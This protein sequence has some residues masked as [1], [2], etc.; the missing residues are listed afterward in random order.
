MTFQWGQWAADRPVNS[1]CVEG[2]CDVTDMVHS[3]RTTMLFKP[4]T[5]THA[6]L[7]ASSCANVRQGLVGQRYT[8]HSQIQQADRNINSV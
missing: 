1:F 3:K 6:C 2:E 4:Q 7:L 8:F 5:F